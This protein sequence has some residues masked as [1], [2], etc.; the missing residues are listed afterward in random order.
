MK[1]NQLKE[2][3]K[4]NPNIFKEYWRS[5][6]K[7]LKEEEHYRLDHAVVK[8]TKTMLWQKGEVIN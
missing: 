8:S 7:R 6:Q 4:N 5:K 1:K 2:M 3:R